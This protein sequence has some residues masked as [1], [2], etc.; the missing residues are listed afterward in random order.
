MSSRTTDAVVSLIATTKSLLRPYG[1]HYTTEHC[2]IPARVDASAK[3][4]TASFCKYAGDL[5]RWLN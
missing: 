2:V 5:N 3:L 1:L 4:E